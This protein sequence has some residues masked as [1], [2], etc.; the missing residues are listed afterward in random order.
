MTCIIPACFLCD[1]TVMQ[2]T[3]EHTQGSKKGCFQRDIIVLLVCRLLLSCD[4]AAEISCISSM[5]SA[6]GEH[7][8]CIEGNSLN[9]LCV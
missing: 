9:Y 2:A 4:T 6:V 5:T 3:T 8:R 7:N 1:F